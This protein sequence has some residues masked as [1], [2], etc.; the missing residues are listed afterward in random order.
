[1]KRLLK[2][3]EFFRAECEEIKLEATPNQA[4]TSGVFRVNYGKQLVLKYQTSNMPLP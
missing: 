1:M 4:G 3:L 2:F